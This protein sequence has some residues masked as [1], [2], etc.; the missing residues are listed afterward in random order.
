MSGCKIENSC[1]GSVFRR[2]WKKYKIINI[3][4]AIFLN[5]NLCGINFMLIQGVKYQVNDMVLV[6]A[7]V[8]VIV[9]S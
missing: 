3:L 7:D 6:K 2:I 5:S 4:D 9:Y 1:G 8:K